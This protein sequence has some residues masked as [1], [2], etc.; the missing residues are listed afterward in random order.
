VTVLS[1]PA[2]SGKTTLVR[3]WIADAGIEDQVAWPVVGPDERDPQRLWLAVLNAVRGTAPGSALARPLTAA[4]G[5]DGWG[6]AERLLTDLAPLADRIWL[7]IDDVHELDSTEALRQLEL[8]L[9]RAPS[10]L[11]FILLTRQDVRLG[12]HRL[13]LD[14][15][16]TE[17][18]GA[19]LRFTLEEAR[20]L[21]ESAG[22]ALPEATL[23]LLLDRTEGWVAG[24]RLAALSLTGHPAPERFVA[25]FSGSE[26]T[27]AEYLL[28]EVLERQPGQVR[29]LLLRTSMLERVNGELA[30]LLTGGSGGER[31]LQDLEQ[32]NAF[33]VCLDA[34]RSWFRYHRLFADLL[35]LELRRTAP[36]EVA[37]LRRTAAG[38][39]AQHG[40]PVEAIRQAQAVRDW[41]L[42]TRLLA[43]HWP[44]LHLD[45]QVATMHDLLTAFPD[46][47]A[48]SDSELAAVFAA[49]ELA[50]GSVETARRYL[51]LAELNSPAVP[52]ER[53]EH[54]RLLLGIVQLM[55]SH[56]HANQPAVAGEA[57]QLLELLDAP[58]AQDARRSRLSEDL[59][60]L[61]LNCVAITES[62]ANNRDV[63]RQHLELGRTLAQRTRRPFLEFQNL[64]YQAVNEFF[65]SFELAA[66]LAAQ[67]I[68]LAE[69]HGW[70]EE[71]ATGPAYT[72][73][74][75][76]RL[77]QGSLDEAEPWIQR[78]ERTI[79]AEATPLAGLGVRHARALLA[80]AR[81]QDA[82][83]LAA[84]Q[85]AQLLYEL[86]AT[87]APSALSPLWI[88]Q[89]QPLV[90]L[91]QTERVEQAIATLG[92]QDRDREE[93]RIV[94]AM[95]ALAQDNPLAATTVLAPVLDDSA[96]LPAPR[97]LIQAYLLDA[98]AKDTL[99][100]TGGAER[101]LEHALDLAEPDG[102]LV[103]FLLH[104]AP[105]LLTRHTAHRTRHASLIAEIQNLLAGRTPAPAPP[106]VLEPLSDSE[107]RVLR[108]LP[109]NLSTPEI[110]NELTVS[111]NT[112]KTHIRNL[113]QKLGA[114][115][116]TEAVA[117]A[118]ALGL[119]APSAHRL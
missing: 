39:L 37:T 1:A 103:W 49:D 44:V 17:I 113:Y 22:V 77:W 35:R 96:S 29:E 8:L 66:D 4:P 38:W 9:M 15:E 117:N 59:R 24:L 46:H 79:K 63:A 55:L 95:L 85:D 88:Q 58:R 105:D 7:V 19:D 64:S 93:T 33:V 68:A 62:L 116:R 6:I 97:G 100:D 45:G 2:G 115:S 81:G 51:D 87:P 118:R 86:L 12:L 90:R 104:P 14:S 112:V 28:A 56:L 72:I 80:M 5:L 114:H 70:T 18:R 76:V 74:G 31:I 26:R 42:A 110:A 54:A 108:Y 41:H 73:L 50:H 101:A 99:G 119:L 98:I 21:L 82:Q 89:L 47:L 34:T 11:R 43:D 111:R 75:A 83:A 60:A 69:R 3:S 84:L 71:P 91:G 57:G 107:I 36:G 32:A 23:A 67:A 65:R 48:R 106:P 61:A 102:V 20:E 109:T 78:A 16:L 25:E 52:A 94:R 92:D 30:D 53:R 10:P 40:Y 27:V 13:R